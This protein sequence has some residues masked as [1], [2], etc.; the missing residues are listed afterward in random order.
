MKKQLFSA[1]CLLMLCIGMR[2]QTNIANYT[3]AKSSGT[4]VP[5]TGAT[6]F[7]NSWDD[8]VSGSIPLGGNFT[9][10]AVTYTACYI[11]SNGYISFGTTA[12]GTANYTPMNTLGSTTGAIAAFA[13]DGGSSTASGATPSISYMNIGGA[14]GEFV[15]Q[16]QDHA[17]LSNRTT[18]RLNFQIRLNL[19]TGAINIVYGSWTA[20]GSSTSNTTAQIGIRGNSTT[21]TSNVNSLYAID[22]PVGTTCTWADAVTSNANSSS[23]LFSTANASLA[24]A[25]GQTFSWGVPAAAVAPVRAFAAVSSITQAS[26]NLSWTAAS[27]ATQYNVQYRIPGTC[28]WTNFSGNPVSTNSVSLTGLAAA[29]I[30]QVRVQSSNGTNNAIWS[31]IPDAA[32]SGDG[33]TVTGTFKTQCSPTPIAITEG[34]N[35]TTIPACWSTAIVAVQSASKISYLSTSTTPAASPFEGANFVRYNS[36][37]NTGGGAGS[38]ERLVSLPLSSTG[39]SSVDV[40]FA[41]FNENSTSYNSGAYLNEGVTVQYSLNGTTWTDVQFFPRYDASV[42]SGTGQWKMKKVT[43]PA[44]AGNAAMFLVGFKFHSEYGNNCY[45]DKVNVLQTPPACV[46]PTTQATNLVLGGITSAV[47]NG[48]YTAASP[49]ADAYLV[50]RTTG[51]APTNPVNGTTYAAGT[52]AL[53]GTVVAVGT[54]TT[55]ATSGLIGNTNYSY[56]V[57]AYTDNLLCSGGPIYNLTSP[58]T[59]TAVTCVA[60]P[61][62][63]TT[64][65]ITQTDFNLSWG[66]S[67]GGGANPVTY[68]VD[69]ATNNTFAS[70]VAGSPFVVTAPSNSVAISGLTNS[71]QYFYRIKADNGC[72]SAYTSTASV[73]TL[74]PPCVTPSTQPT[75]LTFGGVTSTVINGTFTAASPAVTGYLVVRTT[76]AAPTNPVNGTTYSTGAALGGTVVAVTTGTTFAT[77]GL[78]GNT[79]YAYYIFAYNNTACAGIAYNVTAPL[80][81]TATTC[82]ALPTGVTN[83]A[84]T[85]GGFN[86]SWT[87]PAGGTAA[88]ITYSVEVS[89]NSGFTAPIAGSPFAIAAPTTSLAL[90]GLNPATIYYYRVKADNG[91]NIGTTTSAN[92]TTSAIATDLQTVQMTAPAVSAIAC[93]MTAIP[94]VIQVKNA[95]TA[96]LDFST[97]N[98]TLVTSV[99]GPNPQ[100]FTNT[101]STG[102]LAANATLNVT[103][104]T[105]YNMSALG[106][107]TINATSTLATPDANPSNDAMPATVRTNSTTSLPYA[108]D[109]AAGATPTGWTNTSSWLFGTTHGVTNNGIYRNVYNTNAVSSFNLLR[110]GTL[111]GAEFLTFDYRI[112]NFTSYPATATPNSPA[113]GNILVQV[114][115]DC[116]NT[117]VTTYTIDPTNHTSSTSWANRAVPLSAFA[118]QNVIIKM[119]ANWVAGDYYV[120][121]DNFNIASCYPP[122]ALTTANATAISTD[123]AWTA[124]TAGTPANYIWEVRT[125]GAAGS[126]ATGLATTGTV[127]APSTSVTATGLTATTAYSVYV[128]SNCG[129]SDV[130]V[131]AP[132]KTFTTPAACPAPVTLT[133]SSILAQS[134]VATWTASGV[135]TNWFVRYSAPTTTATASGT[136]SYTMTGLTPSTIYSVQVRAICGVG[137]TSTYTAI[138]TFLTPCLPPNITGTTPGTRCGIGTMTLGATGDPGAAIKWYTAS[139]GGTAIGTGSVFT[140]PSI[141]TTTNYYVE[142]SSGVTESAGLPNTTVTSGYVGTGSGIVFSATTNF[143]LQSTVIYPIGTGSVTIALLNSAGTELAATSAIAVTGTGPTTPVT[144]P[145][146]F[147]VTTGT[148]YRLVLKAYTGIT[149]MLRD[150]SIGGFPY[151]SPSGAMSIT[152]GYLTSNSTS[153]YFFYN[154]MLSTGCSSARTAV[155]AN[156]SAP[157][158]LALSSATTV[159]ANVIATANVTSPLSNYDSY[160][161]S[162]VTNLYTDAAATTPYTGGMATTVYFKSGTTNNTVYSVNASNSVSGCASV[163]TTTLGSLLLTVGT[164]AT[165]PIVCSAGNVTLTANAVMGGTTAI[166]T[167]TTTTAV[168]GITPYGSNYEGSRQQYLIRASELQAANLRAG[169]LTSLSFSVTGLGTGT[170]SQNNFTIKLAHTA[171]TTLASAYGTPVGAFTTVY[172]PATQALPAMGLNAYTFATPF[173]WDGTSNILVDICHDNDPTATCSSCFSSNSTVAYSTT[174][175]NSVWGSY[176]DNAASCGVQASNTISTYVNRPN[177]IF[178]GQLLNAAS[179]SYTWQWNPGAVNSSTAVVNPV[180]PGTTSITVTYTATGTDPA[181]GCSATGTTAVVVNPLP[182]TPTVANSTQCGLGIPTASVSGGTSYKWYAAPTSTTVLQSGA[183]QTYT[184][185]INSTTNFYVSTFDGTCESTRAMLTASVTTPDAV[186]A[187]STSTSVCLGQTFTLTAANPSGVAVYN[188][189]WTATPA[190]GSGMASATTAT[191]TAVTP[192]TA[193]NYTYLLTASDAVCTTTASVNVQVNA[194]PIINASLSPTVVCSGAAVT[195]SATTNAI[196]TGNKTVGTNSSADYTGGPYREGAAGN[197]AQWLFTAA[198]LT[199]AGIAP[200]NITSMAFNVTSVGSGT[201]TN[202]TIRMGA[203]SSTSLGATY[204]AAPATIVYGPSSYVAVAGANVH[205]FIT[206]FNWDGVSNVII[207]VCHDSPSSGSSSVSRQSIS[208]RTAYTASSGACSGTTG[209]T[210]AYRPV[211]TFAGQVMGQGVGS[212]AWQ[213]NPGAIGSNTATV[214]PVNSSTNTPTTITYTVTG[215]DPATT[216]SNTAVVSVSVNPVPAALVAHN[217]T[218]CGFGVPTASVTG[219]NGIYKWYATPTS[220][221]VLQSSTTPSYTTAVNTSTTFYVSESNPTCEGPRTMVTVTVT[222]PDAITA[223]VNNNSICPGTAVTLSV[224]Q[225]GSTNTYTYSWTGSPAGSGIPTSVSGATAGITPNTAGVYTYTVIGTDGGCNAISAVSLTVNA[226]PL[227]PTITPSTQSVCIG[228]AVTLT[229]TSNA[230]AF[231]FGTQANQN[232]A[233]TGSTGYP[234]SYTGYYGGQRMQTLILASEL[235]AQGFVAGSK[236]TDLQLPVLTKGGSTVC[237]DFQVKIGATTQTSLTAFQSGLT[238]VV[239]P[240]AYTPVVGTNTHVFSAPY[241]WD[242]TSN[243]ILETTFSNNMLGTVN[244]SV[245]QNNSPTP[246]Q[247]TIVYRA[248]NVSSAATATATSISF[249]Y[250][251]RLDMRLSSVST[252]TLTWSPATGLSSTTGNT[253]SANPTTTTVYTVTADNGSCTSSKVFTL[254]VNPIPTVTVAASSSTLCSGTSASLTA[255]GATTYTWL[256]AG[257]SSSVAVVSPAATTVYTVTGTAL[258]CSNTQTVSLAVTATPT[259]AASVSPTVICA[260]ATVSLTASGATTYTWMPNSS[261]SGTTTAA[262]T[263]STTYT[264]SG[265]SAGCT[266]TRTVSVT[267]NDVPTLTVTANP[268]GGALCTSGATATLTAAGTSTAYAWSTGA[269]TANITVAPSATTV[270]TVTGTNSCGTATASTTVAVA[271]TPTIS[272]TT[273]STLICINNS[274]VLTANATPGVTYSWNTGANTSTISVTPT[275]TTTYTVTGTNACGTAT[276]TIVQNVSTCIGINEL[277]N[278]SDINIYP[279]PASDYVSIAIPAY[280]ASES[281]IVEVTDALGKLVMKEALSRDV[282]TFKITKLEEGVYFFKVIT[283]NQTIKVGKVVK[284]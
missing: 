62:T 236:F 52:A 205:T 103:V 231:V 111:T 194:L 54:S 220:T 51:A 86:L 255:T 207:Q 227:T 148:G 212:Y 279:N 101:I 135:E 180:N 282:T 159:C 15:V 44:A 133:V 129:G 77:T 216:C 91:C 108:E 153:Y 57:Y 141:N 261:T 274:V 144:I 171:N 155:A 87:A 213:W 43:L 60:V 25:N 90:T 262:P 82:P 154:N 136:P 226:I 117:F 169:N 20:P 197:K 97:N 222:T 30:Y 192:G 176:A 179:G 126:G 218:Q 278:I 174:S 281:T 269:N 187:T 271:T 152:N 195:L 22:V 42:A 209:T 56:F 208:N 253:V 185:S 39:V 112:V 193:G 121:M 12:P 200:G 88:P 134:A 202:F 105:T 8:V 28:G 53:G 123:I 228:S 6:T 26:A 4:Y 257:G 188:Y 10:G 265:T 49:A 156:I 190:T 95:G 268:S 140:T 234:S 35:T 283:N 119:V 98:A 118:G 237:N 173:N 89:T 45:L 106:V 163:A 55:F 69:V 186:T 116:G 75:G 161:W 259:V 267:V 252:T 32:G 223:S 143:I 178:T 238:Q 203:T 110:L 247:S 189:T 175:F 241:T 147:M 183:S 248:D 132:V 41:W 145:L 150:G 70:P 191:T 272:A 162:P 198:E 31:H 36:T 71:T 142:A 219:G 276:A 34:F 280:L 250:N 124:P 221:T 64:S 16:Y 107:Y 80:T 2:A 157:P 172:G 256:P 151:N 232:G 201:M 217:S 72:S 96:V 270:Y 23:V 275:V 122:T 99:T 5:L 113:W 239:S 9:F 284:H 24:P 65:G 13:Q 14:S 211:I 235:S 244:Y 243:I 240:F 128:R 130:S 120:D 165:P 199:A 215:T 204:D 146:N 224:T 266:N 85:S 158:A 46:A 67:V 167:G 66:S 81:G 127:T 18:E 93:Y 1:F 246:F 68:T 273:S 38:E 258:G 76:G 17:N 184:G 19:A 245:T 181:S 47:I 260:G 196:T 29:T 233:S 254:T 242:G 168:S 115:T 131:W 27:G 225:T 102:T 125:S 83:S 170:Y 139:T 79:N 182:T 58:L 230:A 277:A 74:N 114:S 164:V 94:V 249:S 37:S 160:V 214:N 149:D 109:F 100:T 206:P 166:G 263:V 78:T 21:W 3:F 210:A 33:N 50:I 84:V 48:T 7:T 104:T 264:V 73:T 229:A 11:S 63:A 177:M 61:G 137:D 59:G 251:A 92:V 40:Q 138:R